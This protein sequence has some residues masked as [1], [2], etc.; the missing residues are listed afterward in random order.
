MKNLKWGD[1]FPNPDMVGSSEYR[2]LHELLADVADLSNGG[3]AD[4]DPEAEIAEAKRIHMLAVLEELEGWTKSIRVEL[5]KI[6]T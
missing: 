4:P 5:T 6:S 1:V 2:A 3:S